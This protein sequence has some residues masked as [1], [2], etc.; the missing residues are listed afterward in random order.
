MTP[1]VSFIPVANSQQKL[2]GLT[3]GF[4]QSN[5]SD[6]L[7][8]LNSLNENGIF[9]QLT[10]LGLLLPLATPLSLSVESIQKFP[11]KNVILLVQ[12]SSCSTKEA[13][14]RLAAFVEMGFR[15]V[16]D[17]FSSKSSLLWPDTKGIAVDCKSGIPGAIRP[18]IFSLHSNL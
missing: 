5:D 14:M 17:D 1:V 15:I 18:W 10:Q 9:D 3:P 4:E 7:R 6:S 16:M 11:T 13:Q 12:E 8:L 2:V